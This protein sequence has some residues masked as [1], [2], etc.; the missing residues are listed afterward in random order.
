[1]MSAIDGDK[2]GQ[3]QYDFEL[4]L[5]DVTNI[6]VD[7]NEDTAKLVQ[8]QKS[9]SILCHLNPCHKTFS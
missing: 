6:K 1:M 7:Q 5:K 2:D 3:L 4:N 9:P 8:Q